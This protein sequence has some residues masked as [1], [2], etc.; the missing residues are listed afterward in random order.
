MK[1]GL[2]SQSKSN[3]GGYNVFGKNCIVFPLKDRQGRIT[4]LYFRETVDN[5]ENRHYYLKDRQGLYPHYPK[6]DS[7]RMILTEAIIDAATLLQIP[8][9]KSQYTILACY[10]TNGFTPEHEQ[11]ISELQNLEEI[12]IFFDGDESGREGAQRVAGQIKAINRNLKITI[13]ET[14]LGEDINSPLLAPVFQPGM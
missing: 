4:G 2:L 11:A 14:P 9:I 7:T 8:G 5:K 12:I 3:A 1:Y 6:S 13:V 10:G